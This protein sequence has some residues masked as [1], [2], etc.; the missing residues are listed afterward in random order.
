MGAMKHYRT[1]FSNK[2]GTV[3]QSFIIVSSGGN[4]SDLSTK[5]TWTVAHNRTFF[6][7]SFWKAPKKI[8]LRSLYFA[9][10]LYISDAVHFVRVKTWQLW[11]PWIHVNIDKK[12]E[13]WQYINAKARPTFV[14][15]HFDYVKRRWLTFDE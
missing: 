9:C 3:K 15:S 4:D 8:N 12:K 7:N 6:G 2:T 13:N 5:P 10:T 11:I 14:Y 1:L